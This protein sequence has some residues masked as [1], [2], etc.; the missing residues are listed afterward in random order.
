MTVLGPSLALVVALAAQPAPVATARAA[1]TLFVARRELAR[2]AVLAA[3]D[4]DTVVSARVAPARRDGA[5]RPAPGWIVR[6]LIRAGEP[7]R[8][9]A[10]VPP[11]LVASGSPVTV[12]W[13]HA[14]VRVT[15]AGTALGDARRGERVL[16]RV[17]A[18]RRVAGVATEPGVVLVARP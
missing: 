11:P 18:Q 10:V 7:L 9:P 15:R 6:R 4:V 3:G 16:V 14:G 1:D 8:A 17:D 2:G 12:V 13:D 5:E